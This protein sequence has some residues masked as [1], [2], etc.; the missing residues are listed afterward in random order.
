MF[1]IKKR[2]YCVY[3]DILLCVISTHTQSIAYRV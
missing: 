3:T 2:L 1:V